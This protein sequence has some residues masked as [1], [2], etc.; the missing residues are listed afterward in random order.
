M[1][2]DFIIGRHPIFV[3]LKEELRLNL[4]EFCLLTGIPQSTISTWIKRKR[5]VESLPGYF[6]VSLSNVG[7]KTLDEVYN[8]LIRLESEYLVNQVEN[9][10]YLVKEEE[11][12]IDKVRKEVALV[13]GEIK[14]QGKDLKV[15]SV[16]KKLKA[17][18]NKKRK[19]EFM[20]ILI[21]FYSR[22]GRTLPGWI[23]VMYDDDDSFVEVSVTYVSALSEKV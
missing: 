23:T 3:F 2:K 21:E 19:D 1:S 8:S 6:F 22:L 15:L 5:S 9:Q 7:N 16:R 11:R 10:R 17:A 12:L 20:S 13:N 18:M 4:S 14:E